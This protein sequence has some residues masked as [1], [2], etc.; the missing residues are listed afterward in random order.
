MT[1]PNSDNHFKISI[2]KSG[3]R[4]G[5]ALLS[6][7]PLIADNAAGA[8]FVL[9]ITIFSAEVLGILEELI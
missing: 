1:Q 5:G 4:L 8:I 6:T 2:L 3:I 7:I 9:A